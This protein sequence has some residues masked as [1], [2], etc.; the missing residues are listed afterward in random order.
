MTEPAG[1]LRG[2]R[3]LVTRPVAGAGR[4]A[5]AVAAEGADA[6]CVPAIV[7]APAGDEHSAERLR[8]RLPDVSVAVFTSVNAVDGYFALMAND[9]GR[10]LPPAVLAVGRATAN[11]LHA[12]GVT[13]VDPAVR[14]VRQRGAAWLCAARWSA[15]L[16]PAG[17]HREGR[18]RA[19]PACKGARPPRRR[20]DRGETSTAGWRRIGSPTRSMTCAN[21]STSSLQRAP[22]RSRICS[23]RRHGPR[24]GC[25]AGWSSP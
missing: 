14:P 9:A 8:A 19:R 3:V 7:I 13:G 23:T 2:V 4:L 11:A 10:R 5:D 24:D 20:G 6:V 21:R 12:R 25:P 17:R 1:R 18:G 22:R 16:G 15:R